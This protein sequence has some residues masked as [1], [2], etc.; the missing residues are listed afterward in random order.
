MSL[1]K[2]AGVLVGLGLIVGLMGAG[3]GATF[4]DT[5]TATANISVGTFGISLSS[6]QG[7]VTCPAGRLAPDGACTIV[8]NAPTI[9]SS[10]P[11]SAP[12]SF[13]VTEN[14]SMPA[15]IHV[16][17][18]V[19]ASGGVTPLATFTDLLGSP[20]DVTLTGVSGAPANAKTYSGGLSW[21]MLSNNDLGSTHTVTYTITATQ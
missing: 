14:G 4:T 2:I 6:T 18:V 10:A 11:S 15:L 5:A 1:R 21:P 19:T 17:G 20:A 13:T 9:Q 3:I 8:Y 12:F 7:I 16:V